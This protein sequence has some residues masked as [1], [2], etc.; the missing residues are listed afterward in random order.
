MFPC[1][2]VLDMENNTRAGHIETTYILCLATC[3]DYVRVR[4][5]NHKGSKTKFFPDLKIS[6]S[7]VDEGPQQAK[8]LDADA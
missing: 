1:Q 4:K 2:D 7:K 8:I 6:T 3:C 5:Q